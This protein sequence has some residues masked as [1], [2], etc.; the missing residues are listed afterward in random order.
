L[1]KKGSRSL[2]PRRLYKTGSSHALLEGCP[3]LKA[4]MT[5]GGIAQVPE[6]KKLVAARET[7]QKPVDDSVQGERRG[8]AG[9]GTR[10]ACRGLGWAA[11]C[12]GARFQSGEKKMDGQS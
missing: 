11:A 5:N 10:E 12:K 4:G 8:S 6:K 3:N 9:R 2:E 7:R 1:S